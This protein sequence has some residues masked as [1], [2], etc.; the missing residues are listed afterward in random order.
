MNEWHDSPKTASEERPIEASFRV[1][2]AS[3]DALEKQATNLLDRL[4]YVSGPPSGVSGGGS[5]CVA[6]KAPSACGAEDRIDTAMG[7]VATVTSRLALAIDRL[8]I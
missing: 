6:P 8:R 7:R 4:E 5:A 1:L 2:S 3:I